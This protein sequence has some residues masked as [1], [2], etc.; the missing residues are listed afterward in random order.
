M[1]LSNRLLR[2]GSFAALLALLS[3]CAEKQPEHSQVSVQPPV[4]QNVVNYDNAYQ[5]KL[6]TR[7]RITY[8]D[9]AALATEEVPQ[10]HSDVGKQK[11]CK[12]LIGIKMCGNARWKYTVQREGEIQV[13]GQDDFVVINVPMRFFGNAGIGGDVSKVLK[14]DSMDFAGAMNTQL[15]LKLDLNEQW[16]PVI[17]TDASYQW[18]AAPRL[19]WAGGM[20]INLQDKVDKAIAK[21]LAGLENRIAGAIDCDEFRQSIQTQWKTH[22][23]PLDLPNNNTMFLNIEPNGFSFSGIR[24]ENHKLGIAF[25]LEAKTSVQTEAVQKQAL[26]LP[27][28]TRSDYQPGGTQFNVLIRAAYTQLQSIAEQHLV[29]RTFSNSSAAGDV[30]VAI[31]SVALSGNPDGIT[32]NLGFRAKLPGKKLETPGNVYLTATPELQAFTQ[33]VSLKNIELSNVLD[34]TLWNTIAAVFKDKIIAELEDKAVFN[35][36]PKLT[37]LSTMLETQLADPT[38]TSGLDIGT[39][40]VNVILEKLVPEQDNFAAIVR[41]ETLLDVDVPLKDI[42]QQRVKR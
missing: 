33:T 12:K 26:D 37:E 21:Q 31:D 13:S 34:S 41:V 40:E 6:S 14:L 19:E 16:C 25:T 39:P 1:N 17:K 10:E 38:R 9:L 23:I 18:T 36:G 27:T 20:D 8:A 4:A 5:S 28:L 30:S 7:A 32:V 11:I 29:G 3:A 24:T 35:L 42:Y 22:S 15:K 2:T